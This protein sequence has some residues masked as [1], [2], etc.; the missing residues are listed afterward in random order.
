MEYVKVEVKGMRRGL[1]FFPYPVGEKQDS[2]QAWQGRTGQDRTGQDR[3][4]QDRTGQ[5]RTG[6]NTCNVRPRTR[7]GLQTQGDCKGSK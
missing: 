7:T 2:W 4:G 3:T 1:R 6:Q 5:D